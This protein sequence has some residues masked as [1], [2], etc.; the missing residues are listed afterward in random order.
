MIA[1]Y[2]WRKFREVLRGIPYADII[3]AQIPQIEALAKR[4]DYLGT[5]GVHWEEM[6][7]TRIETQQKILGAEG[8]I[9]RLSSTFKYKDRFDHN[10]NPYPY[11]TATNNKVSKFQTVGNYSSRS[12]SGEILSFPP[13]LV[14]THPPVV[15]LYFNTLVDKIPELYETLLHKLREE[16]VNSSMEG[17]EEW[18]K[19]AINFIEL[20]LSRHNFFNPDESDKQCTNK[21]IIVVTEAI[22][23]E[24]GLPGVAKVVAQIEH[25]IRLPPR[26]ELQ[27]RIRILR[28]LMIPLG[29]I[30][31]VELEDGGSYHTRDLRDIE[32][33]TQ[34]PRELIGENETFGASG[35]VDYR[36]DDIPRKI[37][38]LRKLA[39]FLKKVDKKSSWQ[40]KLS[41]PSLIVDP[42]DIA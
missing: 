18:E 21:G 33:H 37:E 39:D 23:A 28:D 17:V 14:P 10:I 8:I 36:E 26:Y 11:F 3:D 12:W 5:A 25:K 16:S 15:R 6:R 34:I 31:Y 4:A 29:N 20:L 7:K 1:K 27:A 13:E 38:Q 24:H 22:G 40:R 42:K 30:G 19:R 9:K 35:V 32:R 41:M 2:G